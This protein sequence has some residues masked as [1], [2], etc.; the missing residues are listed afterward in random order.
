MIVIRD[1]KE[2]TVRLKLGSLDK[3]R[4]PTL[5]K[6]AIDKKPDRLGIIVGETGE[7]DETTT[8]KFVQ[9]LSIEPDSSAYKA[10]II[11]GDIILKV[12]R[13]EIGSVKEYQSIVKGL[14]S[15]STVLFDIKRKTIKLFLAFRIP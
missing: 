14:K 10:E 9:V 13:K 7:Q 5:A 6:A 2:R 15:K 11:P 1:R 8:K 4:T 12:N 3:E